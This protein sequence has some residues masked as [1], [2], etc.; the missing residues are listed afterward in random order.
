MLAAYKAGMHYETTFVGSR[1]DASGAGSTRVVTLAGSSL[2]L[3]MP[4]H[5]IGR[6]HVYMRAE[7]DREKL[8]AAFRKSPFPDEKLD[9]SN[10]PGVLADLPL[11][12][13]QWTV[14]PGF[15]QVLHVHVPHYCH[16]FE[17]LAASAGRD[18]WES[19]AWGPWGQVFNEA[20]NTDAAQPTI[21][22]ANAEG[23]GRGGGGDGLRFGS[24]GPL[25]GH[26]L[27]PGG[28]ANLDKAEAQL[29]R[30]TRAPVIGAVMQLRELRRLGDGRL[31]VHAVA[32][33]R[34]R[35]LRGTQT[36]PFSRAD[37][38]MLPDKEEIIRCLRAS[39]RH[40]K[41]R[42]AC[43]AGARAAA[44]VSALVWAAAESEPSPAE[45]DD[46][47]RGFIGEL[48][49]VNLKLDEAAVVA[50]VAAA[51]HAASAFGGD[52]K[53]M[54]AFQERDE[55]FGGGKD[56]FTDAGGL[57]DLAGTRAEGFAFDDPVW[58]PWAA[59]FSEEN[60]HMGRVPQGPEWRSRAPSE[61][62]AAM[63]RAAERSATALTRIEQ[64]VW[65]E[66]IQSL[67]LTRRVQ[68]AERAAELAELSEQGIDV[69]VPEP[70][71]AANDEPV[72]LP[73]QLRLL[74]PPAP[75]N[76]WPPGAPTAPQSLSW[77][78]CYPT[79]RRAQRL[80]FLLAA[81][82]PDLD[83]QQLL[84]FESTAERLEEELRHL[85]EVRSRL[86]AVA[87]LKGLT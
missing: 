21:R 56:G 55:L 9:G 10:L 69:D 79:Q 52:P 7:D 45:G 72:P 18:P 28:S 46:L 78:A 4:T 30:G 57:D 13:V 77:L 64:H 73:E 29:V 42:A 16:M 41:S 23:T 74:L 70:D 71:V 66:L 1:A 83:K 26:L 75:A 20:S 76:G 39:A 32:L 11:W 12:R 60:P 2:G 44:S 34:F 25:F 48:A 31:A 17:T 47:D 38:I 36:A 24:D 35:V 81:L 65:E 67:H 22:S 62:Q 43:V 61:D 86:A 58:G 19:P 54:A 87:A 82:L 50:E 5:R 3:R 51:E 63:Q 85:S 84:A 6:G 80:S 49:N 53:A 8:E 59:V 14:L 37:V 68:A 15:N 40:H 27:L 33:C